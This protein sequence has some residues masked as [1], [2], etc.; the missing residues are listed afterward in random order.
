MTIV[1]W[2]PFRDFGFTA[3]NTWVPPVDIFQS[4]EH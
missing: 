1:G 2:D 4:S 3:A